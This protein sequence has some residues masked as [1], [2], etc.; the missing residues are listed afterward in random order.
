MRW[1]N[2]M[3]HEREMLNLANNIKK[4]RLAKGLTQEEFAEMINKTANYVSQ[5]ENAR[6]GVQLQTVFD[7]AEALGVEV[8]DL[9]EYCG[10]VDGRITKYKK[11]YH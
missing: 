7:I 1:V 4:Y 11:V 9:F 5:L 8:K 6:K 10:R 2:I 3:S